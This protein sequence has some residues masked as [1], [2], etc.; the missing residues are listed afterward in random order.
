MN[1][2]DD[3]H[4]PTLDDYIKEHRL[5]S[6]LEELEEECTK[7]QTDVETLRS[8]EHELRSSIVQL[9][10]TLSQL[11]QLSGSLARV[12]VLQDHTTTLM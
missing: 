11:Y 5:Q 9:S 7:R 1:F 8:I 6:R 10:G 3:D 4:I 2:F 12:G